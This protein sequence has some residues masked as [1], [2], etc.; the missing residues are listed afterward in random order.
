MQILLTCENQPC[1]S[2]DNNKTVLKVDKKLL[3]I[4]SL[5]KGNKTF[6]VG[7]KKEIEYIN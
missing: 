1:G 3:N 2:D 4:V 5:F 6:Q 7:N